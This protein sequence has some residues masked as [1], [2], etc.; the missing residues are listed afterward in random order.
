[1]S[2]SIEQIR[3]R[4]LP[5]GRLPG[6]DAARYLGNQPKT[7]AMWRLQGKGPRYFKVSGRIFYYR[8]DLDAFVRG[9]GTPKAEE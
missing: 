7:L 3:V 6:D 9:G 5:D 4:M 8:D 1:M 2:E